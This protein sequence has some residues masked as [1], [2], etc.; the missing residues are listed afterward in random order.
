MGIET[1]YNNYSHIGDNMTI[2]LS[3]TMIFL[4]HLT[5]SRKEIKLRVFNRTINSLILATTFRVTQVMILE[6]CGYSILTLSLNN[7]YYLFLTF[8]FM[9]YNRYIIEIFGMK[10]NGR[11]KICIF[12]VIIGSI[13]S[14]FNIILPFIL[15]IVNI[16]YSIQNLELLSFN[17]FKITY[18]YHVLLISIILIKY[19]KII[20]KKIWISFVIVAFISVLVVIISWSNNDIS[21]LTFTFLLPLIAAYNL[22]HNNPYDISL[23]TLDATAFEY[24]LKELHSDKQKFTLICLYLDNINN[25]N[26]I[27]EIRNQIFT[28]YEYIFK[29]SYFFKLNDK[30]FVLVIKHKDYNTNIYDE[31]IPK[32]KET[33][34]YLYFK[35]KIDYKVTFIESNDILEKNKQYI[36]FN[37]YLENKNAVN[38]I[39][40]GTEEDIKLFFNTNYIISELYDIVKKNDLDDER[41]LVYCQPVFN[42]HKQKYD[43]AEALMRLN[44]KNIGIV[45]PDIFIPLAEQENCIHIL[46]MIILNKTCKKIK[47]IE[48]QNLKLS[49]ISVNFSIMELRQKGFCDNVIDIIL[50]NDIPFEKI[51]IELTESKNEQDF[52]LIKEKV[53]ELKKLGIYFYLDDFGT[54]YSNFDR[55]MQLPIDIIKFDRS[56]VL[57][58][59]K[60]VNYQYM[61]KNFSNTFEQLGYKILFEGIENQK[62]EDMC[63]NMNANYLQGYKYS[64]PIPINE[65]NKFLSKSD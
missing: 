24:Y 28:T 22:L 52:V 4:R 5:Y 38:T 54:G 57:M 48:Q 43:S 56:L 31:Y 35:Y 32:L 36:T 15:N 6:Y 37:K 27:K 20:M 13:L 64:K 10:K 11:N 63:V 16:N 23:G 47:E 33:L 53:E 8:V 2:I 46:S 21:L 65:L 30:K 17:S 9:N 60:N 34:E 25:Q 58:S 3:L 18:I 62:D 40:F 44:L 7:L 55:I 61:I 19:K 41:V 49:R 45:Y 51:A 59:N 50:Q 42:I 26:Y 12:S 14:I 29:K 1:I 39:N